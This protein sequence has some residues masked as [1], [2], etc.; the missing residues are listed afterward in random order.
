MRPYPTHSIALHNEDY[1][2]NYHAYRIGSSLVHRRTC[3]GCGHVGCCDQSEHHHAR[4]HY[5][6]N[7]DH[8]LRSLEP[9]EA[10]WCCWID[11]L[12]FEVDR[13]GALRPV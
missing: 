12:P 7:P 10:W 8:V 11:D 13:V 3:A 2:R 1:G 6:A 4:H 5:E 9:G